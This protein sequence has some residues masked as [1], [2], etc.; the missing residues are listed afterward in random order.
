[1]N[2]SILRQSIFAC[3]ALIM[4]LLYSGA[5][6][7]RE[8]IDITGRTIE[9]PDKVEKVYT[10]NPVG[11]VF[12]YT[13]A[14]EK[15]AGLNMR[16]SEEE[17]QFLAPEYCELPFLGGWFGKSS[18]G[19]IE[20]IIKAAPDVVFSVGTTDTLSMSL[21]TRLEQQSGIPVVMIDGGLT[22][23]HKAYAFAGELL[24]VEERAKILGDYCYETIHET[25][26]KIETI[27]ASERPRVY[28]AEGPRGLATDPSGSFHTQV[29]DFAGA[30]NVAN[31]PTLSRYGRTEVSLEQ[32]FAWKP[33][34]IIAGWEHGTQSGYFYNQIK[35]DPSWN[36]IGAVKQG[37]VYETP[38]YPFNWFDRPPS[39][40]RILGVKWLANLLYPG[41]FPMDLRKEAKEFYSLFYHIELKE[42]DLDMLLKYSTRRETK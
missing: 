24:G 41:E 15:L 22:Q 4:P 13:L 40:N 23:L 18:T 28:Y 32:L 9:I 36:L 35:D 30:V 29:L 1:M 39:V 16:P 10:T 14:P 34:I 12:M 19:N 7:A 27:P 3:A 8:V 31:V 42:K 26:V 5:A 33:E 6:P 20:E 38:Q 37:H 21:C 11:Q 25:R 17:K 2:H